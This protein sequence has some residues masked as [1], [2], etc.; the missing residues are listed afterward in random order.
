MRK[1]IST[2]FLLGTLAIIVIA[3]GSYAWYRHH[4][5]DWV[6]TTS[7]EKTAQ[8]DYTGG[9]NRPS[10]E[11]TGTNQGGATDNKGDKTAIPDEIGAV[12]S[13]GVLSVVAPVSGGSLGSG[14]TLRG[15][16]KGIARVQYRVIDDQVGVVAQGSLQTV[17]GTYSGT[18]HF[19]A[20]ST[21]GRVDVY[22]Y[23]SQYQEVNEVQI[24][25]TLKD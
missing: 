4:T 16:A 10:H 25:V 19:D 8:N 3:G 1:Y 14:D 5:H 22:S 11:G 17:N 20:R 6:Q 21:S 12:S 24:P 23:D 2:P 9:D 15:T 7:H 13:S 18:L